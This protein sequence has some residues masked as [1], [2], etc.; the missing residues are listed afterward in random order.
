MKYASKKALL[1]DIRSEHDTLIELIGSIPQKRY[2]EPG[3]WGDGWTIKDLLAHLDEWHRMFL[4]WHRDGVAGRS[5]AMPAE[6][7]KWNELRELNRVIREKRKIAS[8]KRVLTAFEGSY[9]EVLS[10]A[11]GLSERQLLS[12][13]HF[14]WT[15]KYTVTTYLGANTASHYRFAI[16]TL[17]KWQSR[18][19]RGGAGRPR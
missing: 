8:W 1:D 11:E 14:A 2:A 5:P 18:A 16:K 19:D 3:V 6:G 15:K 13:G 4:R 10:L 7:Y 9:A 12:P 17:K